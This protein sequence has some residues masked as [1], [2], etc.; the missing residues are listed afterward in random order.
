MDPQG[1]T[2]QAVAVRGG[3]IVWA[4]AEDEVAR[5]AGPQTSVVDLQGKTL[6]PGFY[7]AHDHFPSAGIV[8]LYEVDLNSPPIGTMQCLDD[9]I[10][11]LRERAAQTPKGKWIIERGKLADFVILAENPLTAPA[12]R[13]KDIAV[14]ETIVGGQSVYH[15]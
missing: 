2:A 12:E 10:A 6:L 11:A 14:L 13:I 9:I 4:G 8:A 5:L 1:R 15:K 3:E 7:A